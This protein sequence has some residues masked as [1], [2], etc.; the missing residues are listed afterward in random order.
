MTAWKAWAEKHQDAVVGMG[1][2]LGKTKKITQ[3]GIADMSN[4]VGAY[5]VFA[6]TS[7]KPLRSFRK[8]SAL[9]DLPRRIRGGNAGPAHTDCL[10]Q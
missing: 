8:P 4:E 6:R 5:M 3:R 2:P 7:H 1:G 9:H 10:T